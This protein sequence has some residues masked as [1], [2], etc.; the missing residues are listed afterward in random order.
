MLVLTGT[1]HECSS[2]QPQ[3]PGTLNRQPDTITWMRR[4]QLVLLGGAILLIGGHDQESALADTPPAQIVEVD[5]SSTAA[6]SL[7][8]SQSSTDL[9]GPIQIDEAFDMIGLLWDGGEVSELW[10][11]VR[12]PGGMWGDWLQV[13][14][15]ADH[16]PDDQSG[17]FGS[18]P[19]FTGPATGAR[20][21]IE[22]NPI[23]AEAMLLNT[24][25]I[26]A[27]GA[28]PTPL[29]LT[30]PSYPP[31]P[32][33]TGASFVKN[34]SEWDSA[35]CRKEGATTS[36]SSA[37]A[38]VIHHTAGS[39]S[40]TEA[41]VP[42]IIAGHCLFHVTGRGWD[43]IGYNFLIDK[44]G[45]VWEGRTGSKTS[46]VQGAHTGG[47]NSQTQG[48]AMMGNFD[49]I[50]PSDATITGLKAMLDWLTGWHSIDPTGLVTLTP[51]TGAVG[52]TPGVEFTSQSIV[53]HR[54][55]GSTS[56]PG[57]VFYATLVTVRTQTA[58]VNFGFNPK[59]ILCDGRTPTIFGTPGNDL[60][61]GTDGPDVIHGVFGNDWIFGL[62]GDDIICG[63]S[64]DDVLIGGGGYDQLFGGDGFDACGGEFRSGCETIPNDEMFFYRSD[65][66][67]RFY[68]VR[69]DGTLPLPLLA[70]N[71]Y[72][73]GWSSITAVDLDGDGRDEMF[74]YRNDGLFRY[75]DV[76]TDGT[77]GAPLLAGSNYTAG[78]DAITAIDLDGDG[79][80]EM[81]FYRKDGLFRFYDVN[82]DG[83]LGLPLLAGS[84]Y[85]AGWDAITAVD[86]DGDGQ[87]EMFFY[88]ADGLFRFYDVREDGS[89][90][91]PLLAGSNYTAGWDAITAIDLDGDWQDEMFFYRKD[92]LFRFYDVREDGSLPLPLLAG[93]NYT[94]G[95]DAIT[96]VDLDG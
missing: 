44:F 70:G 39:N 21:A 41:Q 79:Q 71:G 6:F 63:G 15:D 52:F 36:Y 87:D 65:G 27:Q 50:A 30:G 68:D 94:T 60:I 90:P 77:L 89:L 55:L 58:P 51:G 82:P 31:A 14:V 45:T 43:D 64:G 34:R 17:R 47:F 95:W 1:T 96:A 57:G 7:P 2:H 32:S 61:Y 69:P 12:D 4:W 83:T 93:S 22:G 76:N 91:L 78:W 66:L 9:V 54:D 46:P 62:G 5:F 84:N 13:D 35:G 85:T 75:Y 86:L 8:A 73:T 72:T 28:V 48:I 10:L 74:F 49:S 88:R 20:F 25:G 42:G 37:K 16:A 53:G 18:S 26:A 40:Y 11:Q 81:F 29:S 24:Q 56:C 92:G 19:V 38:I 67:F 33:W 59:T 23:G 3:E 80:D